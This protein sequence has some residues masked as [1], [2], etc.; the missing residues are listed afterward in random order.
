MGKDILGM[1]SRDEQAEIF[2][3]LIKTP[4]IKKKAQELA[5]AMMEDVS[6]DS[7]A[8]EVYCALD[9]L[10]VEEVWDNSGKRRDGY[11]DPNDYAW[12]MAE[13]AVGPFVREMERCLKLKLSVQAKLHCQGIL[14]GLLV[15]EREGSNEFKDWAVDAPL[16]L[17][18]S[19]LSA[20]SKSAS[21]E[22]VREVQEF[23]DVL[24]KN[25]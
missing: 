17:A 5:S 3:Q 4:T 9:D 6:V 22:D 24:Q 15:Y 10:E 19:V 16:N 21:P 25:R 14:Q 23:W 20:W 12:E 8:E 11:V 13:V 1:L 7:V 18:D 2:R